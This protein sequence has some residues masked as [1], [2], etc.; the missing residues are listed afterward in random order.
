MLDSLYETREEDRIAFGENF[1]GVKKLEHAKDIL[2]AKFEGDG[3]GFD[4]EVYCCAMPARFYSIKALPTKNSVGELQDG[5]E[6]TTGSGMLEWTAETAKQIS[7]GM[8][9]CKP[10]VGSDDPNEGSEV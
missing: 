8:V 10:N 2:V 1:T 6:L 5:F 4:V 7:G 3:D 9:G